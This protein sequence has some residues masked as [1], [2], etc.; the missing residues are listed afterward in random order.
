MIALALGL[1][2]LALLLGAG[3]GFA[4]APV[5]NIKTL[6]AW[7]AVLG[8]L[9]AATL[10]L[11]TGRVVGALAALAFAV[12]FAW[13]W[14]QE[15]LMRGRRAG[16]ANAGPASGP[17]TRQQAADLLGVPLNA[18][19]PAVQAAWKQRMRTAHPDKGGSDAAAARLNQA[20]DRLLERY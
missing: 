12:P 1:A 4:L 16:S 9:T 10:L 15:G 7:L 3:R 2:A 8:G 18:G 11:L 14:R 13:S 6:L 20:R 19:A 17:M 5:A